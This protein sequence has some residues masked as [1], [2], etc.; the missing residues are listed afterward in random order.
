LKIFKPFDFEI[1]SLN[2]FEKHFCNHPIL[3]MISALKPFFPAQ[4]TSFVF[5]CIGPVMGT[6]PAQLQPALTIGTSHFSIFYQQKRKPH[7]SANSPASFPGPPGHG[8]LFWLW[9]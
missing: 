3:L 8:G 5:L 2:Q 4:T 1:K 9:A 7:E 6:S